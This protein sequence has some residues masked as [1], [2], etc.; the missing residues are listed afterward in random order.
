M[1]NLKIN[2]GYI[3]ILNILRAVASLAVVFM[4]MSYASKLDKL[5]LGDILHY[6]QQGVA[7]FFVISG[8][9]IPYS[10]WNSKYTIDQFFKYILKRSIR[11]D[12][13]Y[14]LVLL[15]C[16][17]YG[18]FFSIYPFNFLKFVFH[19]AYL[20]PFSQY[21]WYQSVFWT[22]GIEF[23][24]YILIGL[25]F[26]FLKNSNIKLVCV[27][28][29]LIGATGYF[30]DHSRN[31]IL[32]NIHYFVI[33]ILCFLY[34]KNRVS[35]K[36]THLMLI[37]LSAF[38]MLKISMVTGLVGYVTAI[39]ILHLKFSSLVT[40][41][42]GRIYYSLYLIHSLAAEFM[43]TIFYFLNKLNPY[44]LFLILIFFNI[45]IATIFYYLIEEPALN[46]AAKIKLKKIPS[47]K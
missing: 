4:H 25:A 5:P 7:V 15:L 8:F 13:P 40:D 23:Q 42:L 45:V 32:G 44:P 19:L 6:G 22:L 11:I 3:P 39:A 10:L 35:F 29:L 33:G 43:L 31:F 18:Y 30:V 9:I 27:V 21:D 20:I 17:I 47:N 24:F 14:L 34:K 26:G 1:K 12:P 38:L 2:T 46:W 28:L 37:V 16:L 41:F 36:L